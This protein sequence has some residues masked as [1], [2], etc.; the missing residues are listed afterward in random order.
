MRHVRTFTVRW[1]L[2]SADKNLAGTLRLVDRL[3]PGYELVKGRRSLLLDRTHS[4]GRY[5]VQAPRRRGRSVVTSQLRYRLGARTHTSTIKTALAVYSDSSG[6]T[7][8]GLTNIATPPPPI[9]SP[10]PP[11]PTTTTPPVSPPTPT[12]TTTPTTKPGHAEHVRREQG[13]R[14]GQSLSRRD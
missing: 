2:L 5:L 14:R 3:P 4:Q 12:T 10:P 11:P 1:T 6:E 13:D 9:E 8:P 7:D